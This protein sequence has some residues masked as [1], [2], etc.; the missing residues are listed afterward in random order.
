VL[1][2]TVGAL[3]AA[4]S[5]YLW[6]R[7]MR[8]P[9]PKQRRPTAAELEHAFVSAREAMPSRRYRAAGDADRRQLGSLA[10]RLDDTAA[11]LIA[12]GFTELGG[13]VACGGDKL[14]AYARAFVDRAGTIGALAAVQRASATTSLSLVSGGRSDWCVTVA[15]PGMRLADPPFVH[16][17]RHPAGTRVAEL[18]ARHRVFARIDDPARGLVRVGDRDGFV[19][20]LNRSN[21][22]AVAWRDAQPADALLDADLH[23]V[24]GDRSDAWAHRFRAEPPRAIAR[25]RSSSSRSS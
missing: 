13:V 14:E 15:P 1:V 12:A 9:S 25:D 7:H 18:A 21:A 3:F 5:G 20:E 4:G 8:C 11:Q 23:A 16:V 19:A 10:R 22:A 2:E 6:L 17:E 24:W